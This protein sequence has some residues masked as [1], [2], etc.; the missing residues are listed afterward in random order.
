MNDNCWVNVSQMTPS[1]SQSLVWAQSWHLMLTTELL[2]RLC[3]EALLLTF[4]HTRGNK[5]QWF[6]DNCLVDVYMM[7]QVLLMA[8]DPWAAVY[9]VNHYFAFTSCSLLCWK[10][11]TVGLAFVVPLKY[12]NHIWLKC[13]SAISAFFLVFNDFCKLFCVQVFQ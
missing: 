11:L 12:V 8:V 4:T 13:H 5:S 10:R 2:S 9:I 1:Q 6:A 7:C 3:Y